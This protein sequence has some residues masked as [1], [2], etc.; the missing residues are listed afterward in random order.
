ME[1]NDD[2]FVLDAGISLPDKTFLGVDCLLPN[3][4]YLIKNKAR[5]RAYIM[6]HGH[7]ESC[8]ALKFVYKKAPAK[9]YCTNTTKTVMM[10]QLFIHHYENVLF[11]FEI[12]KPSDKRII[13]GRNVTFFQ[14]CHNAANSFGVAIATD[15]GNIVFQS[16]Y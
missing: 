6:T 1:I 13:A 10:G 9:I 8:G 4:D 5:I 16:H 11:D 14:T 12:V 15:K 7:D 3:F 2:I